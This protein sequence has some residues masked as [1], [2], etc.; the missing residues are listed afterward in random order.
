MGDIEKRL[1]KT[2]LK[3][4]TGNWATEEQVDGAGNGILPLNANVPSLSAAV[5]ED[6]SAASPFETYLKCGNIDPVDFGLEFDLRY[7]GLGP[8]IAGAFGS[9]ATPQQ[10]GTTS[11]WLH[12][13]SLAD[14]VAGIYYTYATEQLDKFLVVPSIKVQ[15]LIFSVADGKVKLTVQCRGDNVLYDS[16]VITTLAAVTTPDLENIALADEGVFRMNVQGGAA[17]ASGDEVK[18]KNFTLEIER[19]GFEPH[20]NIG[21]KSM[22][23]PLEGEEKPLVRLTIEMNRMDNTNKAY[24]ADWKAGNEKKADFVFTGALIEDTYYNYFKFQFPRLRFEVPPVYED[25]S[26]IPAK[27]IL[28]GVLASS[29]PL[30]MTGLTKPVYLDIMNKR[31]TIML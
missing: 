8:L 23:E 29:A 20:Y 12:A 9:A 11:A 1:N 16:T 21:S 24:F 2:A 25:A 4:A 17:L 22:I 7:H 3:K 26:V 19:R 18:V 30:G 10:Q 13:L 27:I 15:K 5:L 14:K 31:T 6:R 28:R